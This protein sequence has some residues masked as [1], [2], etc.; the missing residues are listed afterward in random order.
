METTKTRRKYQKHKTTYKVTVKHFLNEKN[1]PKIDDSNP[2]ELTYYSVY[3]RATVKRQTFFFRSKIKWPLTKMELENPTPSLKAAL[4]MEAR[5]I[6]VLIRKRGLSLD[7]LTF[8]Y[9]RNYDFYTQLNSKLKAVVISRLNELDKL[10][11]E[12]GASIISNGSEHLALL[13]YYERSDEGL[14]ALQR[15]YPSDIWYFELYRLRFESVRRK[16]FKYIYQWLEPTMTDFESGNLREDY[17]AFFGSE[18][19]K[20][21][22]VFDDLQ[23]ILG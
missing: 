17:L 3:F 23:K 12:F 13:K 7:H 2:E 1:A 15:E 10:K 8:D 4:N 6:E 18:S 22:A 16:D 19:E 11:F 21:K 9:H 14:K 5:N 20:V